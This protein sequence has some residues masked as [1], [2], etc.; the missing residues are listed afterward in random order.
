MT[1][2]ETYTAPETIEEAAQLVSDGNATMFAGGTDLMLQT[3]SGTK[4]F[5]PLLMNLRRIPALR[6]VAES[7]GFIR[8]GALTTVTDVLEDEMLAAEVSILPSVA[9]RFA[10]GQVRNSATVGGNICN[11]SPAGDMIVPLMLLDSEVEL[12]SWEKNELQ[13]RTLPLEAFFVGPGETVIRPNEILTAVSFPTP[14]AEF[15]ARFQKFGTRPAM[16]ISVVSVGVAGKWSQGALSDSKVVFGAVAPTPIRGETTEATIEGKKLD[17]TVV[18][19]AAD[20]AVKEI[21]PISDVRASAWYRRELIKTLTGR[22]LRDVAQ[23]R[24]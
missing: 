3:S 20:A 15:V 8:I 9:D 18:K 5:E 13:H 12:A 22:V 6:G 24:D 7:D 16:D 1:A 2:I 19:A 10:C 17:E 14:S 23:A 21:S 4:Q 11:A